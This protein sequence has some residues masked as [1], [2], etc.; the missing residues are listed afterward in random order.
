MKIIK[1]AHLYYDLMNLYGENGNIRA[2]KKALTDQ[3]ISVI[4]DKLTIKDKI[5]FNKYDVFY[6]GTGSEDDFKL[7]LADMI[8]YQQEIKEVIVQNKVFIA[9]GN[10]LNLFGKKL[11]SL[12]GTELETLNIF[13]FVSLDTNERIVGEQIYTCD[14]IKHKVIGFQNRQTI[15]YDNLNHLFNVEK[16][17]GTNPQ[18]S[19]EGIKENNFYGTYLIG[20]L[21]IR[22]PYFTNYIIQRILENSAIE[23]QDLTE[24]ISCLAYQEYLKLFDK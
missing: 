2:L 22:N 8:K 16:G 19:N 7:V 3:G 5:N 10:A 21:L 9:T 11:I 1:I 13:D 12:D 24:D 15:I 20:P 4:I 6:L 14:L 17:T 18:D 23:Y